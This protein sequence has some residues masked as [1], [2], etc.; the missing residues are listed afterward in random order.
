MRVL[1]NGREAASVDALDRGLQYGDGLFETLAVRRGQARFL[2]R[3]LHRLREGAARLAMPLPGPDELQEAL[4]RACPAGQGVLKLMVTRGTGERG[5]RPP[6]RVQPTWI[7]AAFPWPEF[8]PS[9][10]SAGVRL[11]R[12]RTRLGRNAALAGIKH[13]NRL[14]QVLARAEWDDADVAEGLMMDDHDMAVGGTQSNLFARIAGRWVTPALAEC[15]VAGIMRGA[16]RDW[17]AEQ[18]DP[19]VERGLPAA[20]LAGASA[21]LLTNALIGAWP[22][23]EYAGSPL[24]IDPQAARFNA[25]VAAQ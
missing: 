12:C 25:W 13:L 9:H 8:A 7:V 24:A 23:R 16:F 5:Y 3:H 17:A 21:M 10:W 18:G 2:D 11:R 1:I 15:G 19:V 4:A 22:V 6:R 14:E 20:E